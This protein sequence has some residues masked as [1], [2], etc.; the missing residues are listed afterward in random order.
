MPARGHSARPVGGRGGRGGPSRAARPAPVSGPHVPA[1][2]ARSA[3][4]A[5][6]ARDP[7]AREARAKQ[8][9][10]EPAPHPP[11]A[12]DSVAE[13]DALARHARQRLALYRRKIYLGRG[14]SSKLAE[15]ERIAT[16]AE[17]RARRAR[18]AHPN[19]DSPTVSKDVT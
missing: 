14:R 1:D 2:V 10:T 18:V 15:L 7:S 19:A 8:Q 5:R 16:G 12:S 9:R 6:P 4:R 11:I 13:L 17:R 3:G